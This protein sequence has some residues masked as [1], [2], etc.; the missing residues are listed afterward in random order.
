MESFTAIEQFNADEYEKLL[1]DIIEP[2]ILF[3]SQIHENERRPL[4]SIFKK[5]NLH[6]QRTAYIFLYTHYTIMGDRYRL[7]PTFFHLFYLTAIYKYARNF[8][9]Q[10][11]I[12]SISAEG[13]SFPLDQSQ[14]EK[15]DIGILNKDMLATARKILGK[16]IQTLPVIFPEGA[17]LQTFLP[18]KKFIVTEAS[19]A[20]EH[21]GVSMKFLENEMRYFNLFLMELKKTLQASSLRSD[22]QTECIKTMNILEK[23]VQWN[24]E[25][26]YTW[27]AIAQLIISLRAKVLALDNQFEKNFFTLVCDSLEGHLITLFKTEK[28]SAEKIIV[29][30]NKKILENL[31]TSLQWTNLVMLIGAGH[32]TSFIELYTKNQSSYNFNLVLIDLHIYNQLLYDLLSS[33]PV[34]Q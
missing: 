8:I 6:P 7:P 13:I 31:N 26:N 18:S 19:A 9:E 10:H 23:M 4:L 16:N 20:L 28:A 3:D 17:I 21:S 11:T 1:D 24:G 29:E 12:D 30:R 2:K 5:N 22:I 27:S 15:T 14:L 33:I 32:G 34:E 25:N